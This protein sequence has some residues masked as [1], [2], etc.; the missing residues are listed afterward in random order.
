MRLV[1]PDEVT[2]YSAVWGDYWERWGKPKWLPY[3]EAL[4]PQPGAFLVVTDRPIDAPDWVTQLVKPDVDINNLVEYA[5]RNL[6]TPLGFACMMD[7]G[8]PINALGQLTFAGDITIGPVLGSDG[9]VYSPTPQ[10]FQNILEEEEFPCTGWNLMSPT[11][12]DK[13]EYRQAPCFNDW[14]LFIEARV[15]GVE[16]GF[17]S[18]V[19]QFY[20]HHP[21]QYSRNPRPNWRDDINLM[22]RLAKEKKIV[23]GKEFPPRTVD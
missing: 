14:I 12:L 4:Y 18:I 11:L 8:M 3:M 20:T 2:V 13:V 22:K 16:V 15:A 6:P 21:K 19:R 23:K 7:D 17:D 5:L 1:Q 9:I 10:G